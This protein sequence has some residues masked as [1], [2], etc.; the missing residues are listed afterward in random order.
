MDSAQVIVMT[1]ELLKEFAFSVIE[2]YK[3]QNNEEQSTPGTDPNEVV[4]GLRGI[5][6]L[7]NVSITTAQRYKMTFLKEAITQRGRKIITNVTLA[8]K[9]FNEHK[10]QT[11]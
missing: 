5:M 1:P 6:G 4:Y 3:K 10:P 8:R 11:I 9:L 2:E 7:F